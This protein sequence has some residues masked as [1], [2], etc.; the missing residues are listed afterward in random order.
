[1]FPYEIWHA[2]TLQIAHHHYLDLLTM[3]LV[4]RSMYHIA[5]TDT[6]WHAAFRSVFHLLAFSRQKRDWRS[7]FIRYATTRL[8]WH[9]KQAVRWTHLLQL[10]ELT[11]FYA[12]GLHLL[13]V[14]NQLAVVWTRTSHYGG[15]VL[16]LDLDTCSIQSQRQVENPLVL[17]Y[18]PDTDTIISPHMMERTKMSGLV[19]QCNNVIFAYSLADMTDGA[20]ST[21]RNSRLVK[22]DELYYLVGRVQGTYDWV[23]IVFVTDGVQLVVRRIV[24]YVDGPNILLQK[25]P[26]A[27]GIV[28]G[29]DKDYTSLHVWSLEL[30]VQLAQFSGL[31]YVNLNGVAVEYMPGGKSVGITAELGD[32]ITVWDCPTTLTPLGTMQPT[33]LHLVHPRDHVALYTKDGVCLRAGLYGTV[34]VD[35]YDI[36]GA[37]YVTLDSKGKWSLQSH[38]EAWQMGA[39]RTPHSESRLFIHNNSCVSVSRTTISIFHL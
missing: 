21:L 27:K 31:E 10:E 3:S 19:V 32:K 36:S 37:G 13:N 22:V 11:D 34:D 9:R 26:D 7:M 1:M 23:K 6:V 33:R 18:D 14:D 30:D 39:F 15:V 28:V 16:V 35:V 29:I 8:Q 5:N 4:S 17:W 24:S 38:K 25:S 2:I 12:A 20:V